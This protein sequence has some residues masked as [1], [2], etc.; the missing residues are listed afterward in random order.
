[1]KIIKSVLIIQAVVLAV[2]INVSAFAEL[3]TLTITPLE[4]VTFPESVVDLNASFTLDGVSIDGGILPLLS[5]TFIELGYDHYS[6]FEQVNGIV[7]ITGTGSEAGVKLYFMPPLEENINIVSTNGPSLTIEEDGSYFVTASNGLQMRFHTAPKD[8]ALLLEA[9]GGVESGAWLIINDEGRAVINDVNGLIAGAFKSEVI[10]SSLSQG[11]SIEG[12]AG[13]GEIATVVYSDGTEQQFFTAVVDR[14]ALDAA[15][16]PFSDQLSLSLAHHADGTAHFLLDGNPWY[17]IPEMATTLVAETPNPPVINV[18]TANTVE[19]I[20]SDGIRQVL[21]IAADETNGGTTTPLTET[22]RFVALRRAGEYLYADQGGGE[23]IKPS[24]GTQPGEWNTFLLIE[25][26]DGTVRLRTFDGSYIQTFSD[27]TTR[28]TTTSPGERTLF[29]LIPGGD[30]KWTLQSL[31]N[32]KYMRV[33]G[34]VI[35]M[36]STE[37]THRFYLV[38]LEKMQRFV[39]LRRSDTGE[40]LFANQGGGDNIQIDGTTVPNDWS[41]FYLIEYGDGSVHLRSPDGHYLVAESD[42]VIRA[43]ADVPNDPTLFTLVDTGDGYWTF[44]S[45][46]GLYLGIANNTVIGTNSIDLQLEIVD[47]PVPE[48]NRFVALHASVNE[49]DQ[50]VEDGL[51]TDVSY[52]GYITAAISTNYPQ[53]VTSYNTV[54]QRTFFQFIEMSDG[55]VRLQVPTNSNYLKAEDGGGGDVSQGD[56]SANAEWAT[57]KVI[58]SLPILSDGEVMFRTQNNHY[59]NITSTLGLEATATTYT[60]ATVFRIAEIEKPHFLPTGPVNIRVVSNDRH[61]A[62]RNPGDESFV[63]PYENGGKPFRFRGAFNLID[64]GDRTV[65]IQSLMFGTY[66]TAVNG[67]GSDIRYD[68]TEPLTSSERF[69]VVY[70]LPTLGDDE[71]LLRTESGN[72]I[73]IDDVGHSSGSSWIQATAT[74]YEEA[75]ALVISQN[76]PEIGD[77]T[78]SSAAI[79]SA[80]SPRSYF[81]DDG[82]LRIEIKTKNKV[83]NPIVDNDIFTMF[84]YD[85]GYAHFRIENGA[86]LSAANNHFLVSTSEVS[87]WE[88]FKLLPATSSQSV[89][90]GYRTVKIQTVEGECFMYDSGGNNILELSDDCTTV[91]T[92]WNVIDL[93]AYPISKLVQIRSKSTNQYVTSYGGSDW[94][95]VRVNRDTPGNWGT[96]MMTSY[97]NTTVSLKNYDGYY[98]QTVTYNDSGTKTLT[99]DSETPKKYGLELN[100]DGSVRFRDYTT[101]DNENLAVEDNRR[102]SPLTYVPG[103][104]TD[105]RDFYIEEYVFDE[106][107]VVDVYDENDAKLTI[108]IPGTDGLESFVMTGVQ[109]ING[110]VVNVVTEA[111]QVGGQAS[112]IVQ[113]AFG[114]LVSLNNVDM[115]FSQIPGMGMLSSL[116]TLV[117][118]RGRV[119]YASG[120]D[121]KGTGLETNFPLND[122]VKYF[123]ILFESGVSLQFGSLVLE[124]PKV[125]GATLEVAIDHKSPSLFMYAELPI[126]E[127]ISEST[128]LPELENI[129][130]GI[131]GKQNIPFTPWIEEIPSLDGDPSFNGSLWLAGTVALP[132][133]DELENKISGSVTG[134]AAVALDL[135]R[136]LLTEAEKAYLVPFK[137]FKQ[138][139]VNGE[140]TAGINFCGENTICGFEVS[141]GTASLIVNNEDMA[142]PWIAF[143]ARSDPNIGLPLPFGLELPVSAAYDFDAAID[144]YIDKNNPYL[145][146]AYK[147]ESFSGYGASLEGTFEVDTTKMEFDGRLGLNK[148]LKVAISGYADEN[149][150]T[151]TGK[152]KQSFKGKAKRKIAGIKFKVNWKIEGV[153]TVN[154]SF[155]SGAPTITLS[156]QMKACGGINVGALKKIKGCDS[157]SATAEID[158]SDGRIRVCANVPGLG[159]KC[160]K[161]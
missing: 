98:L 147:T 151:F 73:T 135:D 53:V 72:Y 33:G 8:P 137:L 83:T 97:P 9:A 37:I 123:D 124:A 7:Q 55:T 45:P 146:I 64:N 88:T 149:T 32:G 74:S 109:G 59:I 34:T 131:S 65:S 113:T 62:T 93:D 41:T 1:M 6:T 44:Q 54:E 38:D 125:P 25:N 42:G 12:A 92:D 100:S 10:A 40:Y 115:T 101:S 52:E 47:V 60:D 70:G 48:D 154:I 61:F 51:V 79:R 29:K 86:Y 69:E 126:F 138:L 77:A 18:L 141:L 145:K 143:S 134:E 105:D 159:Q 129:G 36:D 19:L 17:A 5:Q 152:I 80:P 26:G 46:D 82:V 16:E 118:V 110:Q 127:K 91:E 75:E 43:T 23:S 161:I 2:L 63:R 13:T 103:W 153:I 31:Y 102:L 78:K 22:H 111:E 11:I 117:P 56:L 57:F 39:K 66:L 133:P 107:S 114:E 87:V 119:S 132:I 95:M 121:I 50:D 120:A 148:M 20:T 139:G 128:G 157:V 142:N 85:D 106:A 76:K 49:D 136:A 35:K 156:P 58:R 30:G 15:V 21:H 90:A 71:I 81:H 94:P 150:Q 140:L 144:A 112:E 130:I 96:F 28:A 3:P 68:A 155:N 108:P 122:D 84:E 27:G 14:D 67:G 158:T 104:T 99:G 89:Y 160:D 116:D 24:G 4:G